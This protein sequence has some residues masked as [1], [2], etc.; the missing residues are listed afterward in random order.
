MTRDYK[1]HVRTKDV[2][3][4]MMITIGEWNEYY[5]EEHAEQR[6]EE[7]ENGMEI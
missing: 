4:G 3:P 2:K 5:C 1:V 6:I 7:I